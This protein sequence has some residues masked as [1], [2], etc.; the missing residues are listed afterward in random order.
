MEAFFQGYKPGFAGSN[1]GQSIRVGL[2]F[3][4][5]LVCEGMRHTA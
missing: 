1:L 3:Y 4:V 5:V 2:L